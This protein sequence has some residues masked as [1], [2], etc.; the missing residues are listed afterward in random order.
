MFNRQ[1]SSNY[2]LP[3]RVRASLLIRRVDR[4]IGNNY[5][6]FL[7]KS[8]FIKF[9][10]AYALNDSSDLLWGCHLFAL[11]A[12]GELYS[13]YH[14]E[15]T[16][17]KDVPGTAYFLQAIAL[18]QDDYEHPSVEQVQV[19]L[20]L[21]SSSTSR[22]GNDTNPQSH[23]MQIAS[24]DFNLLMSTAVL[25]FDQALVLACTDREAPQLGYLARTKNIGAGSGGRYTYSTD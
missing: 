22:R 6:L 15:P 23:S 10:D 4:F 9:D 19:L 20:L 2:Q 16:N 25:H 17:G 18:L 7:K 8:F 11:L 21:V 1:M 5:Q 12:L 24:A 3:D 14:A 13:C